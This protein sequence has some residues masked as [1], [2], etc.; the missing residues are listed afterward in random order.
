MPLS[1]P[2]TLINLLL[3]VSAMALLAYGQDAQE[4]TQSV[5]DQHKSADPT[6]SDRSLTEKKATETSISD[7]PF[8]KPVSRQTQEQAQKLRE[9]RA[10]FIRNR[11]ESEQT[12]KAKS[13]APFDVAAVEKKATKDWDKTD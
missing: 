8:A 9:R 4:V 6:N 12:S 7:V 2:K 13:L 3:V 5:L 11:V 1:I 10:A